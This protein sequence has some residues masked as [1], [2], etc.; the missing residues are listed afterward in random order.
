MGSSGRGAF[1]V[2]EVKLDKERVYTYSVEPMQKFV[3]K[4]QFRTQLYG[5]L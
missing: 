5:I 1:R 2:N 4:Q 3:A